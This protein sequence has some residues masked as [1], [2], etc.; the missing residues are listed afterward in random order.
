MTK[1]QYPESRLAGIISYQKARQARTVVR[2]REAI[3]ALEAR[4]QA[5]SADS[6]WL[7]S[8]MI[9]N[10]YARNPEALALFHAHSTAL[11][12]PR[13]TDTRTRTLQRRD[14]RPVIQRLQAAISALGA[15]G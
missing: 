10:V 15:K 6:I 5:V 8:G 11:N 12:Q 3:A 13:G 2:L 1:K 4:G 14:K 7:E 9:Y